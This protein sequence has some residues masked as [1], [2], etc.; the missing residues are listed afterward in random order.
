MDLALYFFVPTAIA[1][2]ILAN[3]GIWSP[4]NG[5]LKISAIV[6]TALFLPL[7]YGSISELL[8]RPKPISME[9]ARRTMPEA[10][11]IAASLQEGKAIYIWLQTPDTPEPRAY[12]LPWNKETAKQLQRAQRRAKTTKNGV[13]IRRPFDKEND[14][15]KP[16]FYAEPRKPLP[17]KQRTREV[18]LNYVR[19]EGEG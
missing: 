4:R 5:W 7:S 14:R 15:R 18:P 10:R 16:M 11:L 19:P 8:S 13:K 17:T 3:I 1:A 6:V 12:Q 9:W 2:A